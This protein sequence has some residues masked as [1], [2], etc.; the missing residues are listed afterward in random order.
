MFTLCFSKNFKCFLFQSVW[1]PDIPEG[2]LSDSTLILTPPKTGSLK[3]RSSSSTKI[4]HANKTSNIFKLTS[5]NDE[6]DCDSD[7][8]TLVDEDE[9]VLKFIQSDKKNWP[10]EGKS[11]QM[12]S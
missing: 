9:E 6:D 2:A 8:K 7:D 12:M 1:Y 11:K 5:K 4:D 10:Q 3:S